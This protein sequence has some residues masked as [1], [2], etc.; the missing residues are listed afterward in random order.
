MSFQL[1]GENVSLKENNQK[2][3]ENTSV[4]LALVRP[5]K[6]FI[7]FLPLWYTDKEK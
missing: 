4:T 3:T 6:Q 7:L 2:L 5:R 1:P